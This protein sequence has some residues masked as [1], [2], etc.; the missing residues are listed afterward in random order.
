MEFG[1][2][3]RERRR[4]AGMSQDQLADAA[5]LSRTSVVNIENGRQGV[6]IG[7]LYR[8]AEALACAPGELLP[9]V[10]E[11]EVPD[12]TIGGETDSAR[13][14]VMKVLRRARQQG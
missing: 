13:Q 5:F 10:H 2:R 9:P 7:T 8:L 3:V 1:A 6:S 11:V 4:R 14:A 12:I